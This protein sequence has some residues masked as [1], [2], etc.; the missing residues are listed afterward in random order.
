M[1]PYN[2]IPAPDEPEPSAEDLL[3]RA[4]AKMDEIDKQ[5]EHLQI[6]RENMEEQ[7]IKA[8][9]ELLEKCSIATRRFR[10]HDVPVDVAEAVATKWG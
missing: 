1:G 8:R 9:N 7:A 6:S 3:D 5:I 2:A 10:K 4:M